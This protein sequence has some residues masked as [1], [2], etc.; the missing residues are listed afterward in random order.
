MKALVREVT[1][2]RMVVATFVWIAGLYLSLWLVPEPTTKALAAALSVILVGMAGGGHIP[3]ADRGV[4]EAGAA[5]HEAKTF[6]ELRAAG[7]NT[8]RCWGRTRR[9]CW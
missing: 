9:G 2:P 1:D 8:G 5:A 4:G 7:R 3:G 6:A